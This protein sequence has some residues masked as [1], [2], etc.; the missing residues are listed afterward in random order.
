MKETNKT[1]IDK[2][3]DSLMESFDQDR[4]K[5]IDMSIEGYFDKFEHLSKM[6]IPEDMKTVIKDIK[7]LQISNEDGLSKAVELLDK[8]EKGFSE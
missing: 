5:N 6:D 2:F 4:L 8:I 7:R 1:K 3:K